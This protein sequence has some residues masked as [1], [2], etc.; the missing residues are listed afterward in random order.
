MEEGEEG[1]EE[2]FAHFEYFDFGVD[3]MDRGLICVLKAW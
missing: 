3:G 1:W 2:G